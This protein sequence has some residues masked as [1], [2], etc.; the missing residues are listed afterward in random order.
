M[1]ENAT[2]RRPRDGMRGQLVKKETP[3]VRWR[4]VPDGL[5]GWMTADA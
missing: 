4:D 5:D 2:N 1:E 3:A